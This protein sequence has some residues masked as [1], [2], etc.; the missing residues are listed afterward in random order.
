MISFKDKQIL[1]LAPHTDDGELG[2]GGS[3]ARFVEEGARVCCVAFSIA[4]DSVPSGFAKDALAIEFTQA[5]QTLGLGPEQIRYH[6]FKVRHFPEYRQQILQTLIDL[7]KE[8][9]PDIIFL[10]SLNDIHQDHQVISNEG[11]RA[12]KK[13][14]ILGYEMPWNN[15]VFETRCFV[16]L[17][18]RHLDLKIAALKKYA[19]QQHR[20][21]LSADFIRGLAITRGTQ[22]ESNYAEA[23]EVVRWIL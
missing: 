4:E 7:R 6:R 19:S 11:L 22:F 2:C 20:A 3:I 18:E 9:Q 13:S 23:F 16:E 8:L 21:Y 12:F 10:P 1:V 5:M 17:Q 15:I 14:S